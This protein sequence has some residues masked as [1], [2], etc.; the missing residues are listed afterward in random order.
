MVHLSSIRQSRAWAAERPAHTVLHTWRTQ[1]STYFRRAT[2]KLSLHWG[3]K[4]AQWGVWETSYVKR[5]QRKLGRGWGLGQCIWSMSSPS[6]RAL[7]WCHNFRASF[8]IYLGSTA[9]THRGT[10]RLQFIHQKREH[11]TSRAVHL[12]SGLLHKVCRCLLFWLLSP[13]WFFCDPMDCS[14]PGSSVHRI[15]QTRILEWVAISS[16]TGS[17]QPRDW[18]R[19]SCICR[20]ILYHWAIREV[21]F[22]KLQVPPSLSSP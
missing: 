12:Q 18:T 8:R 19:I 2:D 11:S 4:P 10:Y 17:S 7:L 22:T 16:S 13:V 14:P 9:G 21:C 3:E 15:S 5:T 6:S 1:E 20:Q